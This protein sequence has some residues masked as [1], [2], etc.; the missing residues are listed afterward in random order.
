M[1]AVRVGNTG[2]CRGQPDAQLRAEHREQPDIGGGLGEPAHPVQPVVVGDRQRRKS[3]PGGRRHE[4][5][6][7]GSAIEERIERVTVQLGVLSRRAPSH[8]SPPTTTAAGRGTPTAPTP[9]LV[10]PRPPAVPSNLAARAAPTSVPAVPTD[11]PSRVLGRN[12]SRTG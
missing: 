1:F 8:S 6:R 10:F 12:P 9:P 11:P 3:Q 4:L 7:A 2:A 5:L